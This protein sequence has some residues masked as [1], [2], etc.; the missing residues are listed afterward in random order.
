M[1]PKYIIPMPIPTSPNVKP[2]RIRSKTLVRPE[3]LLTAVSLAA[4]S[5]N[6]A[7]NGSN[8]KPMTMEIAPIITLV[9]SKAIFVFTCDIYKVLLVYK[10]YPFLGRCW[11]LGRL[12]CYITRHLLLD[13]A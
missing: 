11:Y 9:P 8:T 7:T 13:I 5:L 6:V 10:P 3:T 2:Y 1:K 4:V 12:Q